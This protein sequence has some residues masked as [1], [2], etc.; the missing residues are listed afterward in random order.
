MSETPTQG[1]PVESASS[2]SDDALVAASAARPPALPSAGGL[3][4][5]AGLTVVGL[6]LVG[7]ARA[8]SRIAAEAWFGVEALGVVTVAFSV[9][10]IVTIIGP[11]GLSPGITKI[12]SQLRGEGGDAAGFGAFVARVGLALGVAGAAAAT[13]Y[14]LTDSSLTA[15]GAL[16]IGST[17]ALTLTFALYLTGKSL[18]YGEG[19]IR[20]YVALESIGFLVFV[21]SLVLVIAIDA[22]AAIVVPVALTYLPVG[23]LALSKLGARAARARSYPFREFVSYGAIGVVGSL[24]GVGFTYATPIAASFIDPAMGAALVGAALTVLEP[25]YLAPRAIGLVLLPDLAYANAAG[26]RGASANAL[27]AGVGLVS[28]VATPACALL[29]LERDRIL[30]PIFSGAIVGGM[31]LGWFAAAF[32]VS[33]VGAPAVTALAAIS[34]RAAAISMWS[35]LAGFG[36]AFVIWASAAASLGVAAIGLGYFVGSV[37]QVAAPITMATRHYDPRWGSLWLRL[38]TCWAAVVALAFLSPSLI[39][40]LAAL[41][42]IG[43]MLAPEIKISMRALRRSLADRGISWTR[44]GRPE[45]RSTDTL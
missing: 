9:A 21:G 25:L 39:V 29:V 14:A 37:I 23:S 15:G 11:A 8:A 1:G 41:L 45:G 5:S 44:Q 4:R 30:Q 17:A 35:S 42:V 16:T 18:A 22:P 33:I 12:V 38:L 20:R 10:M 24:A 34:A 32:F 3:M 7:T 26:A 27:H 43:L 6:A 40:D 13:I 28:L 31:N 19:R 2:P 36:V